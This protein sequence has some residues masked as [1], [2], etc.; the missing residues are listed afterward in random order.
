[1][2]L[3]ELRLETKLTQEQVSKLSELTI[4]YISDMENGRRNPSDKTKN[5]L[6]KIYRVEPVVIFEAC[7]RTK[8]SFKKRIKVKKKEGE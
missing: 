4:K 8:R 5:K 6:A 1:M 7:Q 3:K 2:N